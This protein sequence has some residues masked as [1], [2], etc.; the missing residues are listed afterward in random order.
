MD[1]LIT[2]FSLQNATDFFFDKFPTFSSQ[3]EDFSDLLKD[4][5]FSHLEKIGGSKFRFWR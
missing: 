1:K 4:D 2:H 5:R 3:K